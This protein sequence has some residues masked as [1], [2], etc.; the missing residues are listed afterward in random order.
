VLSCLCSAEVTETFNASAWGQKIQTQA[1]K[2]SL[3]DF[4]RFKLM[5]ARVKVRSLPLSPGVL[6]TPYLFVRECSITAVSPGFSFAAAWDDPRE[7]NALTARSESTGWLA[8][9]RAH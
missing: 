8:R 9:Q 5:V 1:A 6:T 2:A 7:L 3:G 4:D